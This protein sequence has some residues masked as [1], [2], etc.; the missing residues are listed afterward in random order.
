MSG[1]TGFGAGSTG[2]A[3]GSDG[4][5]S[6]SV[7]MD[8]KVLAAK[9]KVTNGKKKL[10]QLEKILDRDLPSE[11]REKLELEKAA[12]NR[13]V[14]DEEAEVNVTKAKRKASLDEEKLSQ[15][16]GCCPE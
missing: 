1:A 16:E 2:S 8:T 10:D 3:S 6:T 7:E 14:V 11:E 4:T 5:G 13:L 9:A 12:L 15:A